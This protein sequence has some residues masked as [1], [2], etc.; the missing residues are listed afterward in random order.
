MMTYELDDIEKQVLMSKVVERAR[1]DLNDGKPLTEMVGGDSDD[2]QLKRNIL[3]AIGNDQHP[4]SL[5]TIRAAIYDVIDAGCHHPDGFTHEWKF[6]AFEEDFANAQRCDFVDRV[7]ARIV[8]LQAA[9][10]L[11]DVELLRKLSDAKV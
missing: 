2:A 4:A 5:T 6:N 10:H 1:A 3:A 9:P 7:A 11:F 8:E